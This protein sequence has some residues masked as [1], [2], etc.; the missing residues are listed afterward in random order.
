MAIAPQQ[1][2][3]MKSLKSIFVQSLRFDASQISILNRISEFRGKQDL[4]EKQT[5][6]VLESMKRIAIVESN[7]CSNRIEGIVAPHKRVEGIVLKKNEPKNRSEQEIAGYRDALALI[8]ESS[9]YIPFTV[10][11]ILQL[12]AT[13]YRYLSQKGGVYKMTDN[14]IVDKNPDGT[15]QRVRFKAV[16]AVSTS[17]YME[18]LIKGYDGLINEQNIDPL[19]IIPL[20]VLDFL[21]IHP[22]S[23]GNGRISRLITLLLLYHFGYKVGKYISLER[24]F[25]ETK[26]TYYE[27]LE[28]SSQ[29]WH[30]GK[31]NPFPWLN[32]FWGVLLRAFN[33]FESRVGA[34]WPG[35]LSKTDVIKDIIHKRITPFTIS[36]I[37]K[38]CPGVSRDMIRYVVRKLR[39]EKI[40]KKVGVGRGL[41]WVKVVEV[42]G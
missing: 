12:H 15:I 26:E 27:T 22:F 17:T 39:D 4:Y 7:E 8:H 3:K 38:E 41:K 14:E 2:R 11:V 13:L 28:V 21:C 30:P 24:I 18:D 42:K 35:E 10:N 23:D 40:I 16:S 33:E 6:E 31:H 9:E 1:R 29:K 5:P 37:V 34:I 25:E 32:Y 20:T 19:I 36:E